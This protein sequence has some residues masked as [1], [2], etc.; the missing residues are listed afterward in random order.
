MDVTPSPLPVWQGDHDGMVGLPK[1]VRGMHSRRRVAAAD[2]AACQAEP[3]GHPVVTM[4]P[5]ALFAASAVGLDL[6]IG[7][8]C[9]LALAIHLVPHS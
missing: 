9:M 1:V 8:C 6:I 5:L 7:S 2:M 4:R 3:E